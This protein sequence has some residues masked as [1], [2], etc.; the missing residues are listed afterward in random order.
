MGKYKDDP[1]IRKARTDLWMRIANLFFPLFIIH[2]GFLVYFGAISRDKY[3]SDIIFFP[4]AIIMVALTFYNTLTPVKKGP[5]RYVRTY[6]LQILALTIAF[7]TYGFASPLT[8]CFVL[9]L[10]DAY[11]ILGL[12][13]LTVSALIMA[14]F[15]AADVYR[16][17]SLHI[18]SISSVFLFVGA[19][20]FLAAILIIIVKIQSVRQAVLEQSRAQAE[21]ERYRITTLMNNLSQGV[22]SID[23]RGIV[24]TYNAATLNILDTNDSLNGRHIDEILVVKDNKGDRVNVFELMKRNRHYYMRDDLFYHY[25]DDVIRLEVSITPIRSGNDVKDLNTGIE[26]GFLVLLRDVTKQKNLDEER[27]EF[28]SVVSHELRTPLTIA[29]GTL[30][31]IKTLYDKNLATTDRIRPALD[32]AH[33]QIIFLA[34]MVNDLSTLSRAER[35]VSDSAELID[36][37]E[38][39]DSLYA[40]SSQDATAVGLSFN[41]DVQPQIGNVNVS[42]LYLVE[43]LHNFITNAIKYTKEG[44]VTLNAKVIDDHVEFSVQDTGIGISKSDQK[45]IFNKFYRSEDY[46]T[47]ESRGTGLGLYVASKLARKIDTTIKLESRL[48]HGSTFSIRIPLAKQKDKDK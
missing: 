13:G 1:K 17:V 25:S 44:G 39:C 3:V 28:I 5:M 6:G 47:R 35:G 27:D 20:A 29:E 16:T 31:N 36:V 4:L 19:A 42:R 40:E 23:R 15:S 30:D 8:P 37:N 7:T 21:T 9:M 48:N 12:K 41:L 46:R 32:A 22:L 34:K 38:L 14:F 18:P 26:K 45:N 33:E 11:R 2:Q 24:R 10:F 43:L